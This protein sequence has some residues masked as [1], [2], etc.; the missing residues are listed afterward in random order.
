MGGVSN[1]EWIHRVVKRSIGGKSKQT[2]IDRSIK[3]E[4]FRIPATFQNR[5]PEWLI[6]IFGFVWRLRLLQLDRTFF[7][8]DDHEKEGYNGQNKEKNNSIKR[9]LVVLGDNHRTKRSWVHLQRLQVLFSFEPA[10]TL[11]P[12]TWL[13]SALESEQFWINKNRMLVKSKPFEDN[14]IFAIRGFERRSSSNSI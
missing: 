1:V 11:L 2:N 5:C 3:M 10:A 13:R 12:N 8:H 9:S 7:R 14:F 6:K 4:K